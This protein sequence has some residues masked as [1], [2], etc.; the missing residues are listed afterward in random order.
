MQSPFTPGTIGAIAALAREPHERRG[1]AAPRIAR[2][3][4][5]GRDPRQRL[6]VHYTDASSKPA[7]VLLW[8]P[9]GGV[10]ASKWMPGTPWEDNVGA[11]TCRLQAVAVII[12]HRLP[13]E[14]TWPSAARD[15]ACAIEWVRTNIAEY[16]GDPERIVLAGVSS[17]AAHVASFIAGHGGDNPAGVLAVAVASGIYDPSAVTEMPY[18]HIVGTHFGTD[19]NELKARSSVA[20]LAAWP[21][22]LLVTVT[23][24]DPPTFHEQAIL[25]LNERFRVRGALPHFAVVPGHAHGSDVLSLGVDDSALDLMLRELLAEIS[26]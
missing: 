26:A 23:E 14:H 2:D 20:G 21:G 12:D 11:W 25:V 8:L 24:F 22:P 6:D 3:L 4:A 1:Y 5:Y 18:K 17:G 7:P 9:G 13:P 15:V 16:G 19:E 10:N